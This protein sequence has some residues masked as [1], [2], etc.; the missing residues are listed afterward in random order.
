MK[1]MPLGVMIMTA[2]AI[3]WMLNGKP[4]ISKNKRAIAAIPKLQIE[5]LEGQPIELVVEGSRYKVLAK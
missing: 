5:S 4:S 3:V 1:Y 2:I